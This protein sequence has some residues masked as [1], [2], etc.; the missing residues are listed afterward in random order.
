MMLTIVIVLVVLCFTLYR[1]KIYFNGTP[2]LGPKQKL[3][4][5]TAIVTGGGGGIGKEVVRDLA[6]QG[7]DVIIADIVNS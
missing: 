6:N 5:C 2:Y 3:D 4:G 7:C 1:L